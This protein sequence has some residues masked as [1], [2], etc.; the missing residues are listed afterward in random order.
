M[1]NKSLFLAGIR[2]VGDLASRN[3]ITAKVG[4]D[5]RH[6]ARIMETSGIKNPPLLKDP[7]RDLRHVYRGFM[8]KVC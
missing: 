4:L 1:L 3:L 2:K 7:C 8:A 5:A 6:A